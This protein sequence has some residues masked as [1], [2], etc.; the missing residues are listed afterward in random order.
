MSVYMC[1]FKRRDN[2]IPLTVCIGRAGVSS[3][4][5]TGISS[6]LCPYF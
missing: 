2:W 1:V 3:G 5:A 4:I 6:L